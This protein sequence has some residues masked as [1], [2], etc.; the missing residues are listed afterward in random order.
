MAIFSGHKIKVLSNIDAA[1]LSMEDPTNLMMVTGLMTFERPI[2]MERLKTTIQNRLLRFDRFSQRIVQPKSG[3]GKPYWEPDPNFDLSAHLHRIALPSPGDEQALQDTV[4]DLMST[5]LDFSKPLWQ[6]HLIENYG[7]GCVLL[8]RLHHAIADG[9]ALTHVLLSLA[10]ES[11]DAP[12]PAPPSE[13]DYHR[14]GRLTALVGSA[15]SVAK[16]TGKITKKLVDEGLEILADHS[17]LIDLAQ[18]GAEGAT[19][20]GRL[21]LRLPDTK[22]LFKGPLG[23]T[24]RAACSKPVPLKNVKA[25]SKVTGSTINDILLT[26][27]TGALRRYLQEQSTDT[28]GLNFR[29]VIPVN[30]R[31]IEGE[32]E[33]GNHFGLVFLSL[34]VGVEDPIDRLYELKRRMDQLK[35][36]SEAVV[37]LGILGAIG[38]S[39][40]EIK[41]IIIDMFQAKATAVMTNVP[42]PR[43]QLYLA[44]VPMSS[45]MFW[46]P[47]AG[48]LG[49]GISILSYAGQVRLGV[50]TD[51]GLVPDPERITDAFHS[52]FDSLMEL[53]R[54]AEQT[55]ASS[56]VTTKTPADDRCHAITTTGQRCKTTALPDSQYCQVH[57][58]H[59]PRN[60]A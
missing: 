42:G 25:I 48:R 60:E 29:A 18:I 47:Q 39:P 2:E 45:V 46:V 27:M 6:L 10:D 11:P 52:E 16:T 33:L 20:A 30:L 53:V 21:F 59:T 58:K 56:T 54:L 32:P 4:S 34:P 8:A 51:A 57:R 13:N 28:A 43:Q 23:V 3:F 37:A 24:K 38:L 19:A 17:H 26:A 41:K 44:G 7:E 50:A 31:P 14:P 5:P 36:S 15:F 1:W 40:N 55:P 12:E 35:G 49:L 22:T 9:I